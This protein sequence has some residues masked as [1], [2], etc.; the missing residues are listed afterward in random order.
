MKSSL[1]YAFIFVVFSI[2][3]FSFVFWKVKNTDYTL[4]RVTIKVQ[5]SASMADEFEL[6]YSNNSTFDSERL[7]RLPIK[8]LADKENLTFNL[9]DSSNNFIRLDLCRNRL[10]QK[11]TIHKITFESGDKNRTY[12][13]IRLKEILRTNEYIK[14]AIVSK[15][16]VNYTFFDDKEKF[17]PILGPVNLQQVLF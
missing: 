2:A 3:V 5:V 9:P 7:L 16:D 17:D 4:K 8:G 6:F 12:K 10:Q 13:G 15:T 1:V 11:V 14:T